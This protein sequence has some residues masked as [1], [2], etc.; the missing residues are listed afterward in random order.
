[1]YKLSFTSVTFRNLSA[2]K[3]CKIA[4]K[5]HIEFI[6][7]G[8]DIH[9]PPN[10]KNALENIVELQKK[11]QLKASSY[12]SY[13]CL[14]MKDFDL[15]QKIVD[16]AYAINAPIIRVWQG[17]KSSNSTDKTML[18]DMLQETYELSKIASQKGIEICF[19]FHKNTNNDNGKSC[20]EFLDNLGD[21]NVGTYWQQLFDGCDKQNLQQVLPKLRAIHIFYWDKN[22]K[23]YLLKKGKDILRN[24]IQT[25]YQSQ[26][27]IVYT[28]EFVKY[29][30]KF[31]FA[32]D[33][34]LLKT[35]LGEIYAK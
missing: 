12:G 15:W 1:M 6:E 16:T 10:D 13:Y 34:Q 9:L 17:N 14:G 3:V 8:G 20:M 24:Y 26:K 30:S 28:I 18:N 35:I 23:R 2:E 32:K 29:N 21:K 33:A 7:W 25:I 22:G 31:V 19:E 4:Q 11:Y 27:D 5:N